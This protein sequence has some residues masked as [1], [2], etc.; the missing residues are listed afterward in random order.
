MESRILKVTKFGEMFSVKSEKSETGQ[1][2]K[3][4]LVLKELGGSKYENDYAVSVLGEE[5]TK[6][7]K[8]G[9]VVI[10]TL[11][12]QARE[13]NGQVFQDITASEIVKIAVDN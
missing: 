6:E 13:Y 3:R 5:A 10:A 11:R 7:L 8:E 1:L 4:N 12:F 9:D 2:S